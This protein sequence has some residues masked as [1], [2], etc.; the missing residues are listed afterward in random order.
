MQRGGIDLISC[1]RVTE[2]MRN[3]VELVLLGSA[4]ASI[5]NDHGIFRFD[6]S[7]KT[8]QGLQNICFGGFSI[9]KR[10]DLRAFVLFDLHFLAL[11][12]AGKV[13]GIGYRITKIKLRIRILVNCDCEN[14][15]RARLSETI[16][17]HDRKV[18][19]ALFTLSRLNAYAVKTF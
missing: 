6:A 8:C 5:V 14:V 11:Q 19:S 10:N 7:G 9:L 15:K 18:A 16:V 4:M 3:Q 2:V 17:T 12:L 13:S 1:S